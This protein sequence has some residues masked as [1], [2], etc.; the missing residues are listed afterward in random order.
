MEPKESTITSHEAINMGVCIN[1][2]NNETGSK[3]N[4]IDQDLE[5]DEGKLQSAVTIW[6][7]LDK[8]SL[9]DARNDT[10]SLVELKPKTGRFHQ[11]RK[12]MVSEKL[13]H[14]CGIS[15]SLLTKCI[16]A[17]LGICMRLPSSG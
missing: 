11:L 14:S 3:W 13:K 12:H 1:S 9:K 2:A 4:L 10:V 7:L 6:R 16:H 8:W 17:F 15:C 5:T